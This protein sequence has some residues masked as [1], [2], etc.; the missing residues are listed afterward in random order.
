MITVTCQHCGTL[1]NYNGKNPY[2]NCH[3][4][5]CGYKIF[6]KN[7]TPT[8]PPT[9]GITHL[10]INL[11]T[12]KDRIRLI[13][14]GDVH[15]GAKTCDWK[16]AC[17]EL[18]YIQDT[19]DTYLIGMGDYMDCAI[20]MG[21]HGPSPFNSEYMPM[22][23]FTILEETLK[24]LA[25]AGKILGMHGGNHERWITELTGIDIINLLCRSLKVPYL[26]EGCDTNIQVNN[27]K[28]TIYSQHG[29]S[30][31]K[32]KH[33]KM[34]ALINATRDIYADIYL[35]GHMHQ[36]GAIKGGK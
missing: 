11:T 29:A 23:Q 14:W 33:T 28:Y 9:Q 22:E 32:L 3:N 12:T 36:I 7:T 24:P 10:D 8:Q 2:F 30:S 17:R 5:K 4:K 18:K 27:T 13:P 20:K 25:D 35:M 21:G 19:P 26:G 6:I 34:G 31:A 1:N 16:K 15:V